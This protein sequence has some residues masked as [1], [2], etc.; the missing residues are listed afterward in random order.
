MLFGIASNSPS[1]YLWAEKASMARES[2][3]AEMQV[4]AV[5]SL[6]TYTEKDRGNVD[7]APTFA[8]LDISVSC[9]LLMTLLEI[10]PWILEHTIP[11]VF[12]P[13]L[14]PLLPNLLH[15]FLVFPPI[16]RYW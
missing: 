12:C 13:P 1:I 6:A 14:L 5:G 3:Q 9:T 4:L 7:L 8:L 11:L 2:R 15:R 10:L 16:L